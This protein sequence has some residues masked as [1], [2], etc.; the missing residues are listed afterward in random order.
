[1]FPLREYIKGGEKHEKH[2]EDESEITVK[3]EG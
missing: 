3:K 1:M 2:R